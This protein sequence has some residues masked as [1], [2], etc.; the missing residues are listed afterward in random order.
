MTLTPQEKQAIL[1]RQNAALQK[2]DAGHEELLQSLDGMEID[3][4]FLASRWSVREVLLHLDSER[5]IDALEQIARGERQ[6]LP[7]FT[8][9]EE[10]FQQELEHQEATH[11]R[12][13]NLLAGLTPEQLSQ[14]AT[15]PNPENA[16]PGLTLLELLE[17]SAGHEASHAR[18]IR[19][20]RQYIA[21]FRTRQGYLNIVALG[22][23]N[24]DHTIPSVKD[25]L[26]M[27]D[28]LIGEPEAL[29]VVAPYA[30]GALLTLTPEN[31]NELINRA[32]REAREGLWPIICVMGFAPNPNPEI[33]ALAQ[34]HADAIV[35]HYPHP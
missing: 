1:K 11:Q 22:D 15:P 16:F 17:R 32:A 6:M 8:S 19:Q 10:H 26:N 5:Y 21:A 2:M 34:Q 4:A 7:P 24:P 29:D 27:A 23:G 33:L 30:R 18:Q 28:Y 35:I 25:L 31:R 3:E 13:R 9:R 20:T 12:L 14:P